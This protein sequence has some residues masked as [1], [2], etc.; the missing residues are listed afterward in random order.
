MSQ[1]CPNSNCKRIIPSNKDICPICGEIIT[2]FAKGKIKEIE[3]NITN[4]KLNKDNI[5]KELK[6][7]ISKDD[8]EIERL[9]KENKEL[10][11]NS[12]KTFF[13]LLKEGKGDSI[14]TL[15]SLVETGLKISPTFENNLR[16]LIKEK[17]TKIQITPNWLNIVFCIIAIILLF[18]LYFS[19][20]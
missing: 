5:Y 6:D 1:I 13:E 20:Q 10:Q 15:K 2:E 3:R 7:K 19:K 8:I 11:T 18:T 14:E 12:F 9:K 17:T 4:K 16:L